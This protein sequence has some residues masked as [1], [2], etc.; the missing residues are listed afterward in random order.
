M[1]PDVNV[2]LLNLPTKEKEAME[3]NFLHTSMP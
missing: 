1:A 2:V 3:H